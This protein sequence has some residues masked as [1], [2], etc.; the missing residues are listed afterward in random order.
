VNDG[1]QKCEPPGDESIIGN[2]VFAEP[3][4]RLTRRLDEII[5]G[6]RHRRDLGAIAGLARSIDELGL[7]QPVV[8]T[9]AGQLIA[10]ERRLGAAKMLGWGKLMRADQASRPW[11]SWACCSPLW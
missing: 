4:A 7:L 3:P 9:P 2:P 6:Q 8:L 1:A 5:V 11:T 10:G